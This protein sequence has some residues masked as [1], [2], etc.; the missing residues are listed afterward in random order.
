MD[1][2]DKGASVISTI[3][4]SAE[5]VGEV[6]A[7]VL[8]MFGLSAVS[9]KRASTPVKEAVGAAD[10]VSSANGESA[11]SVIST[12]LKGVEVAGAVLDAAREVIVPSAVRSKT[13][14]TPVKG[15]FRKGNVI[16]AG[17]TVV[18]L[19]EDLAVGEAAMSTD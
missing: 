4:K 15:F 3:E 14:R 9:P 17:G 2:G 13:A 7:P 8:E 1:G 18:A 19:F 5:S 12:M 10:S 16:E 6:F 11:E